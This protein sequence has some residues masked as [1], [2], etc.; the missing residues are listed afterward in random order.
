[1]KVLIFICLECKISSSG[2]R[3][4]WSDEGGQRK[5][6]LDITRAMFCINLIERLIMF[7]NSSVKTFVDRKVDLSWQVVEL[8][9]SCLQDSSSVGNHA[10][11]QSPYPFYSR[12][13]FVINI[14]TKFVKTLE[15]QIALRCY[16]FETWLIVILPAFSFKSQ[17]KIICGTCGT[18]G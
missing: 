10:T 5:G 14:S 18:I 1:M 2:Y 3:Q 4:W 17:S 13:V 11:L 12:L 9:A 8:T 15:M 7:M 16:D 6:I